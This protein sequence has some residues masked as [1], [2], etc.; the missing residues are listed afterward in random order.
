MRG[1]SQAS[2]H[3]GD[4]SISVGFLSGSDSKEST[5]KAGD[6]VLS[7]GWEGS[8]EKGKATTPVFLP[9]EFHGQRGLEG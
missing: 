5:C 7:L 2:F 1:Y 3:F 4:L 9:G 8:T 6:Q